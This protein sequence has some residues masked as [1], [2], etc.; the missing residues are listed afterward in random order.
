[1]FGNKNKPEFGP[2]HGV[3]VAHASASLAGPFVVQLMA[4]FGADVTWLENPIMPDISRF[5][6]NNI[7]PQERRNQR[8]LSV[9][10]ADPKGQE[11]FLRLLKGVDVF[12]ETSKTGQY[13]KWGL[14]DEKMWEA[15]PKLVICHI[16]G[17]GQT[18]LPEYT[19]RPSFDPLA[20]A[21]SG[22]MNQQGFPDRKPIAGVPFAADYTTGL[23]G[24]FAV[25][26][27][28]YRAK[29][30]GQGEMIDIAQYEVMLRSQI[31]MTDYLTDG[32]TY[33]RE[34][35]KSA[36][37]AGW[38]TYT[39]KDG[40]DV[41]L[42]FI[43]GGVLK[44]GLPFLGL[45][46]GSEDFPAERSIY[47]IDSAGGR[48]IEEKLAAYFATRTAD[49][50]V[51]EMQANSIPVSKI[52]TYADLAVDPHVKQRKIFTEWKSVKGKTI[53]GMDVLPKLKNNPGKVWRY[54]PY[55]G[56]DNEEI[57]GELG[58]SEE[59]IK[60]LYE[61]KVIGKNDKLPG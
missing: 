14:T 13:Q 45:E 61:G 18:G 35:S 42:V 16:S 32:T 5:G 36:V 59:E 48:K 12:V 1:M 51:S 33:V 2:L 49:E 24:A 25:M 8:N 15:N 41:Y 40:G 17:F 57:L 39:C 23:Y 60:V 19:G 6:T 52:M 58:Y 50:A 54:A 28:L 29:M 22:Y 20:Q 10:L 34:G 46:F 30:T 53:K 44:K 31:Y 56:Q 47:T 7:I 21:F 43:G 27:A 4:D 38:G 55:L 26:A 9:S 3:K 11:V 37:Y